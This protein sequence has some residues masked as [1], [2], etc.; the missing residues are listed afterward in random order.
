MFVPV[1]TLLRAA[2]I[3]A[4]FF[5][6]TAAYAQALPID[7]DNPTGNT[8][9]IG[10][11]GAYRPTYEGSDDYRIMPAAMVRGRLGGFSFSSRDTH[12]AIDLIRDSGGIDFSLGPIVGVRIDRTGNNRDAQVNALGDR[13]MA[14][15]VGGFAGISKTGVITSAYD[16]IGVQV[17]YEKDVGHAHRSSIITTSFDYGTP[18]SKATFVGIGASLE[19]VGDGFASYYYDVTPAGSIASGLPVFSANGGFKSWGTNILIAQSLSGDLRHGLAVAVIGSYRRL[20]KDF[21]D[22]P[23]VS[24]AGSRSQWT[25]ALGL[26]YTF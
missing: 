13:N 11:G 17:S 3:V 10:V 8:V 25:G 21:A 5:A 23:I 26:A 18:L 6:A 12:L 14:Y 9:T 7:P 22:S 20:Q 15:E 2:I 19:F 24:V 16:T 1:N 4:P